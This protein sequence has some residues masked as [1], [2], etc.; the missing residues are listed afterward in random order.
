MI[1]QA[2]VLYENPKYFDHNPNKSD[3]YKEG[4]EYFKRKNE[5]Y[6]RIEMSR[7]QDKQGIIKETEEFID[8][9][10][11]KDTAFLRR[12]KSKEYKSKNYYDE[13]VKNIYKKEQEG[14]NYYWLNC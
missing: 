1:P 7:N 2:E 6:K 3:F 5:E 14:N 11:E 13:Y 9:M 12:S 4:F 10:I 8:K